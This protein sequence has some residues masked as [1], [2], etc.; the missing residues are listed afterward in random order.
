MAYSGEAGSV[1]R[2]LLERLTSAG[3]AVRVAEWDPPASAR[4]SPRSQQEL[5]AADGLLFFDFD[6]KVREDR[7]TALVKGSRPQPPT[8]ILVFHPRPPSAPPPVLID[9]RRSLDP[10]F[11]AHALGRPRE[12]A[13]RIGSITHSRMDLKKSLLGLRLLNDEFVDR[14]SRD[15]ALACLEHSQRPM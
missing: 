9:F 2:D 7:F 8:P 13:H 12:E 3:V 4:L 6:G 5:G 14:L 15:F 10:E 1:I 11:L